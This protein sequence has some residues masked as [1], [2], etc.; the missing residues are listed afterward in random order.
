M[1]AGGEGKDRLQ[2]SPPAQ[3]RNPHSSSIIVGEAFDE[4]F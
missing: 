2:L 3:Q 4:I 1:K